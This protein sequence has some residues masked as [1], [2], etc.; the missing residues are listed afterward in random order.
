M[1]LVRQVERAKDELKVRLWRALSAVI[2]VDFDRSATG[3]QALGS[4][5]RVMTPDSCFQK[6]DSS[7]CV[8]NRL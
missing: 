3:R 8:Y 7:D 2:E 5:E 6:D 1:K 4:C